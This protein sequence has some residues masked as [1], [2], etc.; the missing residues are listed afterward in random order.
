MVLCL[1]STSKY[2]V[3]F[4]HDLIMHDPGKMGRAHAPPF[5]PT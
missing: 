3:V 1:Q 4:E 2:T 5:P